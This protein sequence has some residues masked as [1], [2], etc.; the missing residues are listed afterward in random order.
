MDSWFLRKLWSDIMIYIQSPLFHHCRLHRVATK[1]VMFE[2][3]RVIKLTCHNFINFLKMKNE[4]PSRECWTWTYF[5]TVWTR[6]LAENHNFVLVNVLFDQRSKIS[7]VPDRRHC[8]CLCR[9][10]TTKYLKSEIKFEIY[11][12]SVFRYLHD[13]TISKERIIHTLIGDH[14]MF[15]YLGNR[16]I[17]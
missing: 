10:H 11:R 4:V 12:F 17:L 8:C 13:S 3:T 2:N 6:R 9:P 1:H 5:D 15:H 7:R 16:L 14:Q